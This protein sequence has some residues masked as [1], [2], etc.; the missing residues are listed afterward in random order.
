MRLHHGRIALLAGAMISGAAY[1]EQ[2]FNA[3]YEISVRDR[4]ATGTIKSEFRLKPGE[5]TKL[6]LLPNQIQ[7][8]VQSVSAKEYDLHMVITPKKGTSTPARL[9]KT[10]RGQ[11]GVPL[12]LNAEGDA[13]Q[14]R[15]A[16]AVASL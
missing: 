6:E 1:A 11:Y 2:L 12:E 9:D 10:F 16:I 7:L 5:I 8:S 3:H 15:G 13:L 4:G 14:V